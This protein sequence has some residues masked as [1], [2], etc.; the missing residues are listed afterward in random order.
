MGKMFIP[1]PSGLLP[2]IFLERPN[3]FI[4]ICQLQSGEIV[5]AHLADSGRL[6]ELL[7][8]G[9]KV[10][11]KN[12][13]DPNRKTNYS[14][15]IVEREDGNGWVSINTMLPN[16]LA[17]LAIKERFFPSL[18]EWEYVRSEF[19]KGGSRWDLLLEHKSGKK[20]VVEVKGASLL[21]NGSGFFPDAVTERGAKHVRELGQ[22]AK[23]DGWA[24]TLM[25]VAQREDIVNLYPAKHIDPNFAEAMK[26]A[27]QNGV[28]MIG[29]RCA[30]SVNGIE[31]IDTIP[32]GVEI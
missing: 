23:E 32:V 30:V 21:M 19:K 17:E 27:K 31:I 24:S 14:A 28:N 16:K 15:V 25:F 26:E 8:P 20:M 7:L 9:K 11:L 3:R 29:C 2:G 1:F 12:V 18:E 10:Y 5:T 6:K 13:N 22:I 4:I